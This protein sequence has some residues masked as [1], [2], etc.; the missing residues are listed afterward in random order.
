MISH[1][2][3]M[4]FKEPVHLLQNL[5]HIC[6]YRHINLYSWLMQF[7]FVNVHYNFIGVLCKIFIIITDQPDIQS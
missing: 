5:F 4:F 2:V 7:I 1:A 6:M 3:R